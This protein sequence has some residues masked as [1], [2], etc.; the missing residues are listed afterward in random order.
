M[1]RRTCGPQTETTH[2]EGRDETH[3]ITMNITQ[4][5]NTH[6]QDFTRTPQKQTNW[7]MSWSKSAFLSPYRQSQL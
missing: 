3:T 1:Q 4:E 2:G 6:M 5:E 7:E